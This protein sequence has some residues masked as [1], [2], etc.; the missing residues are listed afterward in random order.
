MNKN[1]LIVED[2]SNIRRLIA[3]YFKKEGFNIF[4]A[5]DGEEALDVFKVYKIDLVILDIM[6]PGLNGLKVCEYIR[7]N[8]D[9]PIIMLTAKTQEDDKILGFEHGTDEY[10][11][12]PFSPKVL[13][14]RAKS[15]L[16]RVDGTISKSSNILSEDGLAID[17]NSGKVTVN[18]VEVML[19]LKEYDLLTYFMQNKGM[20]LSKEAILNRVWG[21]D[22]YGDPRTVDTHIKRLRDKLEDRSNYITTIRGRG[23]KFEVS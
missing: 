14:A 19:T 1:L 11:T 18:N 16:K 10:V 12:K 3:M 6:L 2:E 17:L 15:L 5:K 9:V 21:Y 23:Y 4:E 8:S 13:V 7:T 20:V 22:Y